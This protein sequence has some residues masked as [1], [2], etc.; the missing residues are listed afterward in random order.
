MRLH[1]PVMVV[2]GLLLAVA[3]ASA[4]K[5]GTAAAVAPEAQS[6]FGSTTPRVVRL[7]DNVLRDQ[8]FQT[9]AKGVVQVLWWM[10]PASPSDRARRW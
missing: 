10:A 8:R 7:G 1:L 5:V 2:A 4:E 9:D 6:Y 3:P